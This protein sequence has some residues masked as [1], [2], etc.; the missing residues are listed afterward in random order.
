MILPSTDNM[1]LSTGTRL[2]P[3]RVDAAI[4]AGGMGAR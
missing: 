2:G 1:Q 4:G 3:Y